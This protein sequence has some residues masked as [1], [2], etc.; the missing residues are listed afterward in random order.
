MEEG[1]T[2]MAATCAQD[3]GEAMR[4]AC[5]ELFEGSKENFGYNG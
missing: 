5:P 1:L 4:P 3:T 2:F